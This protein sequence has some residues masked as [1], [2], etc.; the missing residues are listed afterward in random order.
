MV[1]VQLLNVRLCVFLRIQTTVTLSFLLLHQLQDIQIKVK[2]I[3]CSKVWGRSDTHRPTVCV[4]FYVFNTLFSI[5]FLLIRR[6]SSQQR[7]D[8]ML[9][10]IDSIWNVARSHRNMSLAELLCFGLY[11]GTHILSICFLDHSE[12]LECMIMISKFC[13]AS[14]IL[15]SAVVTTCTCL[16]GETLMLNHSI[17]LS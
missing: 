3:L 16:G 1:Q 11:C 9:K 5:L 10:V 8:T 12:I 13:L 2:K 4:H 6:I 14:N 15:L 17:C 7:W